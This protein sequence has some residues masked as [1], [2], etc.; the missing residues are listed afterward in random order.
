MARLARFGE[1]AGT[2]PAS[3]LRMEPFPSN[4]VAVEWEFRCHSK[5]IPG[6]PWDWRCRSKEG[7]LVAKSKVFFRSLQD[8]VK[9]AQR[10]G[11]RYEPPTKRR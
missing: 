4:A 8:A 1:Y 7:S 2:L 5:E 3:R 6:S 9:D 11:F 10:N